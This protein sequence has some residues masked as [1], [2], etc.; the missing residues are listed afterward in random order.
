MRNFF[1]IGKLWVGLVLMVATGGQVSAQSTSM[2]GTP[3]GDP[4]SGNDWNVTN[5]DGESMERYYTDTMRAF[6]GSGGWD[7][8]Y[9]QG[10]AYTYAAIGYLDVAVYRYY[11]RT[12][13]NGSSGNFTSGQYNAS[14]TFY[15]KATF[16]GSGIGS[17]TFNPIFNLYSE[18]NRGPLD[19]TYPGAPEPV[20]DGQEINDVQKVDGFL[21]YVVKD[22]SNQTIMTV[23]QGYSDQYVTSGDQYTRS[24][25]SSNYAYT[26]GPV[27]PVTFDLQSG[28]SIE[29][30]G[31]ASATIMVSAQWGGTN[32]G[33]ADAG[34]EVGTYISALSEGWTYSTL[35]GASLTAVPEP[36]TY[37]LLGGV[38]VLA[39][40]L[41]R[42]RS[43]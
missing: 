7:I 29:I 15:D 16:T 14:A 30:Y 12:A 24:E 31:S 42:R 35:S 33:Q 40:A 27:V 6:R 21:R 9:T 38:G 13:S 41:W 3:T 22:E 5:S 37:A 8:G 1:V 23:T 2:N 18:Y 34:A 39:F 26:G 28:Y 17:V 11:S 25:T 19:T 43:V 32:W 4:F 10:Y 36:S 20:M